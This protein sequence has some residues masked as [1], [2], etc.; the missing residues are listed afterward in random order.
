MNPGLSVNSFTK[1]S[2]LEHLRTRKLNHWAQSAKLR[3][4]AKI[5]TSFH[6]I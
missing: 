4:H 1:N 5:S 3:M 6:Y 2:D